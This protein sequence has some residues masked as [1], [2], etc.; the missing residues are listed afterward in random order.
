VTVGQSSSSTGLEPRP[1]RG[2]ATTTDSRPAH[3]HSHGRQRGAVAA[4]IATA[5]EMRHRD[6]NGVASAT[7]QLP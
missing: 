7:R 4:H 1:Q 3:S 6:Y 5:D 2:A